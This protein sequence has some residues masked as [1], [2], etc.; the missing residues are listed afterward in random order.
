MNVVSRSVADDRLEEILGR[1]RERGG[2]VTMPRR[3]IITALL[4]ADDHVTAD[5]L[6]DAVRTA[7]PEIHLST[8]YRTV[9]T[10]TELGVI[11]HVHLGHGPAVYHLTDDAHHH[12]VCDDCGAIIELPKDVFDAL[13]RRVERDYGFRLDAHHFALGGHCRSCA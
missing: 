5:A 12:L 9:E 2:R 3:A 11:N 13:G 6:V 10:L 4:E 7:Q 8:V 1:L